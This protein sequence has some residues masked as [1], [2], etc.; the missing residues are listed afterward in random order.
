MQHD[1][2]GFSSWFT[3]WNHHR[4]DVYSILNAVAEA[5]LR[6]DAMDDFEVTLLANVILLGSPA[7]VRAVLQAGAD[8]TLPIQ[9]DGYLGPSPVLCAFSSRDPSTIVPKL[10]VLL[11]HGASLEDTT[12]AGDTVESLAMELPAEARA[13]VQAWLSTRPSVVASNAESGAG[14]GAAHN[15]GLV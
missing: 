2:R 13:Q 8:P 11:E 6:V 1:E 3:T 12:D 4:E 10:E 9:S 15:L 7:Q 14:A 5:G